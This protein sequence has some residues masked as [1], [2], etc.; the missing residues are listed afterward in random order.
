MW[1]A[2]IKV[3]GLMFGFAKKVCG[4]KLQGGLQ[5]VPQGLLSGVAICLFV[6]LVCIC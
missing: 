4:N 2:I 1:S 6:H 5:V 3:H